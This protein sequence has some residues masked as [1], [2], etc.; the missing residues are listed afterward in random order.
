MQLSQLVKINEAGLVANAVSFELMED[1]DKN[2]LLCQGFVFNYDQKQPKT[3]TVGVLDALW[4]SFHSPSNPNIHL[5]VQDYGKGKSH[6]ALAIANFF[7]KPHDSQ[8]VQGVLEQ[9]KMATP[10][11]D[12]VLESLRL[13]KQRGRHLVI[14]LSGDKPIDL[15]KHFLQVLR[16]ALEEEQITGAIAQQIC[17][18]PLEFLE[19]LS[20]QEKQQAEQLLE[21]KGYDFDLNKLI[22]LLKQDNYQVVSYV[23]ELC[24]AIKGVTPDFETEVDITKILSDLAQRLCTGEN[25]R[26]QGILIIFDELL[27][28]LQ[29]WEHDPIRAGDTALQN[30]AEACEKFK[31][32]LALISFAQRRL[33]KLEQSEE[34]DYGKL[35]SRL[36]LPNSTY[37]PAASLE[38]V[39]D[40]LLSQ[41]EKTAAWQEFK[42]KWVNTFR[43]VSNTAYENRTGG[44]YRS[45]NWSAD[46]FYERVGIGCFPLHPLTSYLLCNLDFTQ[47]RTAIQFVQ[48]D[49]DGVKKF[50]QTETAEKDD[51][52]NLIHPVA[53]VDAFEENFA[54]PKAGPKYARLF[55]NFSYAFNKLETLADTDPDELTVLKALF[56]F[57]AS[58]TKLTKPDRERHEEILSLLTGI[59][60]LKVKGILERLH[61]ARGVIYPNLRGDTYDFFSGG[62][63]PDALRQRIQEETANQKPTLVSVQAHCKEKIADYVGGS[64]VPHQFIEDCRLR[65]EDW[66]F[67]NQVFTT[68]QLKSALSSDQTLRNASGKGIV[69]Y[70]IAGT[71]EDALEL[72]SEIDE[73]LAKSPIKKQVVVAIASKSSGLLAKLLLEYKTLKTKSVQEYGAALTELDKQYEK[74]IHKRTEELFKSCTYHCH[75]LDKVPVSDQSNP[76]QIV[77]AVLKDSYPFVPSVERIDKMALKSNIGSEVIGYVSKRLLENDLRAPAFPKKNYATIVDPVFAKAWGML[78]LQAGSQQYFVTEPTDRKVKAAWEKISEMTAVGDR[79]ERVVEILDI[80]KILSTPPYGYNEYTFT[81]LFAGWLAHHRTEIFLR[82]TPN[83][84]QSDGLTTVQSL[85]LKEWAF[86]DVFDKPKIFI[87]D[88]VIKGKSQLIRRER[89]NWEPPQNPITYDLA[90][91]EIETIKHLLG[92]GLVE[93]AQTQQMEHVRQGLVAGIERIDELLEP[94][95][96]AEDLLKASL[97]NDA[98]LEELVQLCPALREAIPEVANNSL[99]VSPTTDQQKRRE[100]ALKAIV[101]RIGQIIET[102]SER[103][104]SLRSE[105]ECGA[106]KAEIQRVSTQI[107]QVKE[108]PA[109][110]ADSLQDALKAA[111]NKLNEIAEQRKVEDCLAQIQTLYS[112]L[113]NN[114]TQSEYHDVQA[115]IE[116]LADK[117]PSVKDTEKYRET[118]DALNEKQDALIRQV[119]QWEGQYS[120]AM[121]PDQAMQLSQKINRQI[122]RFTEAD[123]QQRLQDLLTSL[124]NIVLKGKQQQED[125]AKLKNVLSGAKRKLQDTKNLKNLADAFQA[126]QDLV[127]VVLPIEVSDLAEA[128]QK[129]LEALKTEGYQ[130]IS[131]R[132]SQ[133]IEACNRKINQKSDYDQLKALLQRGQGLVSALDEFAAIKTALE[134]AERNLEAQY[135]DWKKRLYDKQKMDAIRQHTLAKANTIHLCE[136]SIATIEALRLELNYPEQFSTEIDKLLQSFRDKVASFHLGLQSLSDRLTTIENHSQLNTLREEYAKLDLVF[137]EST[138]YAAYLQLQDQIQALEQDLERMRRLESLYQ[139][140]ASISACDDALEEMGDEQISFNDLE[141]FRPKL[142]QFEE[143]L[144][145]RKQEQIERLQQ[146]ETQIATI[147]TLKDAKTLQRELGEKAVEYRNSQ[148]EKRYEAIFSEVNLLVSLLQIAEAQKFDTL[149]GCQAERDR[150]NHWKETVE[151]LSPTLNSIVGSLLAKVDQAQ[152]ALQER[153]LKTATTWLEALV[154]QETQLTQLANSDKQLDAAHQLLKQLNSQRN[155]YEDILSPD[156]RDVLEQI[157]TTCSEIQRQNTENQII[158]LFRGLTQD[159]RA[160]LLQRLAEEYAVA[161]TE[162]FND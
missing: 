2:R 142:I 154:K 126:Y 47:G 130:F 79:K 65:Q 133:M 102:E 101:S 146:I 80:W 36:E 159:Q 140:S 58:G 21:Q 24:K 5:M 35:V 161:K 48:D 38:L 127:Q 67:E 64:T 69:A 72:R 60:T 26:F 56:L 160:R 3:S 53:L 27:Y 74:E 20:T 152:H 57:Y 144:H 51:K 17:R 7:K 18:E 125:E 45:R 106:Y 122:D 50:I 14:C 4:R 150:L 8:E 100:D 86:K 99:R 111:D 145:R 77:S 124:E 110:F 23:R 55:S 103:Y 112:T 105:A 73:L 9:V 52:P 15:R 97:T 71:S 16:K 89:I 19:G 95:I 11:T 1:E 37:Q 33:K 116:K 137:K 68:V 84:V 120:L 39:L 88:W 44:Y 134:N 49:Q 119:A 13:Y 59:P 132:F 121:Q 43:A 138:G 92:T 141:R 28:Y 66:Y 76:P 129:E 157:R 63:D 114:A 75:I 85:P 107:K 91:Q 113:S 96:Q 54:D 118:I 108:L 81:I 98:N 139:G 40:G 25:P 156:Q 82:G 93:P 62:I 78:R 109:R 117:V 22:N 83:I 12:S 31:G 87:R 29:R 136:E 34:D 41:Q 104:H 131:D 149:Q 155:K 147:T 143:L 10:S 162:E 46:R 94:V 153:Q 61:Q 115:E 151:E 123:S 158:T 6:F 32:R 148:E 70:A 128:I 135:E 42:S 90:Q 30:I